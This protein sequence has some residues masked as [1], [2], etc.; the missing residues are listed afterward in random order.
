[1]VHGSWNIAQFPTHNDLKVDTSHLTTNDLDD[2]IYF[3]NQFDELNQDICMFCGASGPIEKLEKLHQIRVIVYI[4]YPGRPSRSLT[5]TKSKLQDSS[6][7]YI[8]TSQN[9]SD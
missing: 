9:K 4:Q 5:Q 3:L 8:S 2:I 6:I 7:A 1:M